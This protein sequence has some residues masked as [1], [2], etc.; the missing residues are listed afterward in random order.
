MND[1]SLV[2][3]LVMCVI[4]LPFSLDGNTLKDQQMTSEIICMMILKVIINN[5]HRSR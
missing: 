5:N 2:S 4:C 3:C 1:F